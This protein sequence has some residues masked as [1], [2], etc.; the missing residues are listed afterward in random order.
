MTAPQPA[1]R[2]IVPAD[3]LAR[4]RSELEEALAARQ[5]QLEQASDHDDVSFAFREINEKAVE[6]VTAALERMD[7]GTYGICERCQSVISSARLEAV[8]T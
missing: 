2:D 5:E 1:A 3:L 8:V 6:E 7:A 4:L